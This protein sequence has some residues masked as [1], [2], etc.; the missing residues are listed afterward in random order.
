MATI[1]P[2]IAMATR[3]PQINDPA[4]VYGQGLKLQGMMNQ[5]ETSRIAMEDAAR[6]RQQDITLAELYKGAVGPDGNIDQNKLLGG[7]A[8][9]G[10]GNRIPG[11]A[12]GFADL[13]K[14]K[15]DTRKLDIATDKDLQDMMLKGLQATDASIAA[16][17]ADPGI[18]DTKVAGELGRLVRLGAFD[19]QAK[20]KGVTPDQAAK[21]IMSTM[22]VG[23]P[24][25]LKSW[26]IAAGMRTA[27][28][29]KRLEMM[30]P[31]RDEQDRGGVI[32]EGTINPLTGERTAG[33][34]TPKTN[35][36]GE[37]LTAQTAMR[38]Q[39][40]TDARGRELNSIQRAG[41]D[42]QRE[43][44]R[45]QI[46]DTPD[47]PVRVDKGTGLA[48]PIK[49][50][51]GERVLGKDS[52]LAEDR[53]M[54]ASMTNMI[55]MGRDLLRAGPTSSGVGAF[56]DK[57]AATTGFST[58][59]GNLAASLDSLGAWMTSNVPRMQGPQSDKDTL[60]YRQMGGIVGDRTQPIEARM[61]ALD[62]VEK[63]MQRSA[64]GYT[65]TSPK[66]PARTL[67]MPS[68]P[69]TLPPLDS[70]FKR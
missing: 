46:V 16:M 7:A 47:G 42:V 14:T 4:E 38:G 32:N 36:P 51:G 53:R 28:A 63:I 57:V 5:N 49:D 10:L 39:N 1:D 56:I 50:A 60:L 23:N 58:E 66:V 52:K 68:D 65:G 69:N 6:A 29:S 45:T 33:A 24:A 3:L 61:A 35:T 17:A 2:S 37:L 19:A 70:F 18:N 22:P 30:I 15:A 8:A 12:K 11:M 54:A 67:P 59:S 26:L 44:Q 43:A 62:T 41:V 34:N 48:T 40:L 21:E 9:S 27:D 20:I 13:A 64:A 55:Q 31:K 25:A